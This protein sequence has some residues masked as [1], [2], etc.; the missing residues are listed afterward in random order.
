MRKERPERGASRI[1]VERCP[2]HESISGSRIV[3]IVPERKKRRPRDKT[4][5]YLDQSHQQP[6]RV[7]IPANY[8][9][10]GKKHRVT[11]QGC[12]KFNEYSTSCQR[13]GTWFLCPNWCSSWFLCPSYTFS[14]ASSDAANEQCSHALLSKV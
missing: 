2:P 14:L 4:S 5:D 11:K 8:S 3:Q 6:G 12:G 13:H 1:L 9:A 10:G 7:C